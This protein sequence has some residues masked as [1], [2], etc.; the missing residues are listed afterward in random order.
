ME[1]EI[2]LKE[3]KSS[4]LEKIFNFKNFVIVVLVMLLVGISIITVRRKPEILGIKVNK[5]LPT[6]EDSTSIIRQIGEI[7]LL[8]ENE[9][10]TVATVSDISRLGNQEFYKR[11]QN[12]DTV[13][14]YRNAGKAYLYRK[15]EN[16]IIEVGEVRITSPSP[17]EQNEIETTPPPETTNEFF[18]P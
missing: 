1:N 13:L 11:A 17:T 16:K 8:P 15:S 7:I 5:D 10:P 6:V 12:G 4:N 3:K 14:I 18:D 9:V 2:K